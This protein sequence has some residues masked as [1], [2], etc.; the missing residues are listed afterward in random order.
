VQQALAVL[1][2]LPV[3]ATYP[4]RWLGR[5]LGV[6]NLNAYLADI[7]CI[8]ATASFI[9]HMMIRTEPMGGHLRLR[10]HRCVGL[11]V[12][13]GVPLMYALLA[14][15]SASKQVVTNLVGVQCDWWLAGYWMVFC[16]LL[17]WLEIYLAFMLVEV[18]ADRRSRLLAQWYLVAVLFAITGCVVRIVTLLYDDSSNAQYMWVFGN[19][20]III[21][22]IGCGWSYRAKRLWYR[23]ARQESD[24]EQVL[25]EDSWP[26][27]FPDDPHEGNPDEPLPTSGP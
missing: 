23:Y 5:M 13:L 15:S 19:A 26:H 6:Y 21:F 18:K 25:Q 11:P 3:F 22:A 27:S 2:G 7:L 4:G 17:L 24:F 16:A 12:T 9:L 10:F 8:G 20:S 14:C 1:L